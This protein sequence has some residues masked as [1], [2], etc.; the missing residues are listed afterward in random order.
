MD[1]IKKINKKKFISIILLLVIIIGFI[2]LLIHYFTPY[3]K[4]EDRVKKK[5][6]FKG[7]NN[8]DAIGWLRIQGTNIDFPIVYYDSTDVSDPTYELGWSYSNDKKQTKKIT[9]FS[10]NVLNVSSNPLITNENHKRFE[11]LLSFIYPSFVKENKYIQYTVGNKNYLYK[12]YG[13][14]FQYEK[15][16]DYKN[17][18]PTKK[19]ASKYIKKTKEQ[20]YFNF[21]T[22][23]KDTD[24]LLTLVTCTRF[25]GETTDYSFVVDARMVRKNEKIKNYGITEKKSYNRIKKIM[26]GDDDDEEKL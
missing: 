7:I 13:I 22:D 26:K 3:Y 17:T 24:K 16:L 2:I 6:D 10:H 19:E 18:N 12:I 23:V 8:E 14:S 11:Q 1:V 9:I 4:I 25:F 5:D 15:K 21:N 20:S